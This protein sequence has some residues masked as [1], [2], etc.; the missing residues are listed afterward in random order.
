[1]NPSHRYEGLV[2]YIA[3]NYRNAVEIG[4]GHFPDVAYA[5]LDKGIKVFATD[6]NPYRYRGLKVIADDVTMPDISL[7]AA[8]ELLYSLRPPPELVPYMEQLARMLS[9]D[10]IVKPL[11]SE[12]LSGQLHR[13]GDTTFSLWSSS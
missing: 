6:V 9:V 5:L 7:Y 2:D 3:G 4:I 1:M 13:N 8:T 10:L 11:A 12:Y